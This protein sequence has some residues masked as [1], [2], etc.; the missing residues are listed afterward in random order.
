[1]NTTAV[2]TT[3]SVAF[4]LILTKLDRHMSNARVVTEKRKELQHLKE[5]FIIN[6]IFGL[7]SEL[8]LTAELWTSFIA[9]TASGASVEV[10]VQIVP[11]KEE[12][13]LQQVIGSASAFTVPRKAEQLIWFIGCAGV[14]VGVCISEPLN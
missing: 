11:M 5:A 7:R 10:G 3:S 13:T 12:Q 6:T 4:G 8:V 2:N 14:A 1:M 9:N